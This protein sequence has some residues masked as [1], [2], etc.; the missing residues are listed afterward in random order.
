MGVLI[1]M[2]MLIK[3][4]FQAS[5]LPLQL[6]DV[7]RLTYLE[8]FFL[9][10]S[11]LTILGLLAMAVERFVILHR[12]FGQFMPEN[13]NNCTT[14]T[15]SSNRNVLNS[16]QEVAELVS[17]RGYAE[18]S[19][20]FGDFGDSDDRNDSCKSCDSWTCTNDFIFAV[21]LVVNLCKLPKIKLSWCLVTSFS[22]FKSVRVCVCVW[23][24]SMC[25]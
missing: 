17:Y 4:V 2:L 10:L 23:Y 15:N 11:T 16:G 25:V 18:D 3:G 13:S 8:L 5:L 12:Q 22:V 1:K 19:D 24:V 20:D 21:A 9:I 14:I 6:R 7:R